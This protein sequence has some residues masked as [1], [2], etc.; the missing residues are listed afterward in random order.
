MQQRPPR[1][2]GRQPRPHP[3]AD[4]RAAGA[5][6][7]RG[8]AGGR[9]APPAT[10][11]GGLLEP[12]LPSSSSTAPLSHRHPRVPQHRPPSPAPLLCACAAALVAPIQT[13]NAPRLSDPPMARVGAGH[14]AWRGVAGRGGPSRAGGALRVSR[15]GSGV[16]RV[17]L[18]RNLSSTTKLKLLSCPLMSSS[19]P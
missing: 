15:S 12:E 18:L 4:E 6:P 11:P 9:R 14:G 13:D 1:A 19:D 5:R 3:P 2:T 17:P 7:G 16:L 10:T 8:T